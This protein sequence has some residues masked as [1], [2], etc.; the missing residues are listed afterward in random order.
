LGIS[1]QPHAESLLGPAYRPQFELDA[2]LIALAHRPS[3][4]G[5]L[6]PKKQEMDKERI[7]LAGETGR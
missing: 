6:I 5:Q 4:Y 1:A 2:E 3:E 7:R